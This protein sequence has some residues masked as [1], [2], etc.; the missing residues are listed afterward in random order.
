[1]KK[2]N[3]DPLVTVNFGR[4]CIA[5]FLLYASVYLILPLLPIVARQTLQISVDESFWM[6]LPFAAGML[7]AAPFYAYLGDAYKRKQVLMGAVLLMTVALAGM[8]FVQSFWQMWILVLVQGVG[9]G[10]A[11]MAGLTLAIDVT[12]SSRRSDGNKVFAV[13][14]RCGMLVGAGLSM[15]LP[16]LYD[17]TTILLQAQLALLAILLFVVRVHVAFRAPIGLPLLSLDRFLLLRAWL[18]ALNV[19][20][21]SAVTGMLLASWTVWGMPVV[22]AVL[23]L[24]AGCMVPLTK[25]FVR[26]SH[27][28]QRATANTTCQLAIDGGM[29]AG[30]CVAHQA[31]RVGDTVIFGAVIGL[32]CFCLL[33]IP[34]YRSMRVR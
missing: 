28:C 2:N 19:A 18:P 26:L 9:F 1:M 31:E 13:T 25:V 30:L 4:M 17:C 23:A 29:L 27:H 24:L 6:Y 11:E 22:L 16:S 10:W 15:I 5:N 33:T 3:T 34:Y 21:L 20:W 32:L 8:K 7:A 14:G 12:A